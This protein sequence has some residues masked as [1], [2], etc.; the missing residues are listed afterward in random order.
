MGEE[1]ELRRM[2]SWKTI[3]EEEPTGAFRR[4]G[5]PGKK[6]IRPWAAIARRRSRRR[7]RSD[8]GTGGR[9]ASAVED[10]WPVAPPPVPVMRYWD[11][12]MPGE[13]HPLSLPDPVV[14]PPPR[15]W[16]I[17]LS[18]GE[19]VPSTATRYWHWYRVFRRRSGN[20]NK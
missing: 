10:L 20:P 19:H 15:R 3:H 5:H 9:S 1:R 12:F 7:E 6:T 16:V 2:A 14:A 17:V 18:T 11:G 4:G 13:H 8:R